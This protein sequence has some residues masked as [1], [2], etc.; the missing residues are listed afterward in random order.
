MQPDF[1]ENVFAYLFDDM[2]KSRIIILVEHSIDSKWFNGADHRILI[3]HREA[4][5]DLQ[6]IV[7]VLQIVEREL[8]RVFGK[9]YATVEAT[10]NYSLFYNLIQYFNIK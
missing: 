9:L 3:Y 8:N 5:K 2:S 1:V 6:E 7:H 10:G 4:E